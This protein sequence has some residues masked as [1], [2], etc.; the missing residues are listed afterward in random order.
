MQDIERKRR[1]EEVIERMQ[2]QSKQE[3]ELQYETF[4]SGQCKRIIE[5]N[6]NLREAKY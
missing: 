4:R 6:R 5:E 3:E 1:E 2:R